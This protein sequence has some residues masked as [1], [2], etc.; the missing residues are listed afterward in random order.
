MSL[1][2]NSYVKFPPAYNTQP[3]HIPQPL[4]H[5]IPYAQN[6]SPYHTHQNYANVPLPNIPFTKYAKVEFPKF[7][8]EDLRTW[9]YKVERFFSEEKVTI[10]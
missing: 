1:P 7:N 4:Y 9:L 3:T 10:Q 2:Y 6:N 5:Q 8:G